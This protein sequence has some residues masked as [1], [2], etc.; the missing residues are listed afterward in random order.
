MAGHPL[1]DEDIV[2]ELHH[3]SSQTKVRAT[4]LADDD[5]SVDAVYHALKDELL[6]HLEQRGG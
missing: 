6:G 1:D 3:V 5:I 2:V 4:A